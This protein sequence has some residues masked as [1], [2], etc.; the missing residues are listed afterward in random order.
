MTREDSLI[1]GTLIDRLTVECQA[2]SLR[3]LMASAAFW[4]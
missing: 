1:G 3:S 2:R 4:V